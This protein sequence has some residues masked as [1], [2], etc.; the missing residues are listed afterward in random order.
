VYLKT[1][2]VTGSEGFLRCARHFFAGILTYF[3]EKWRGA[4]QKGP[5]SG[6]VGSFQIHPRQALV[7]QS[8]RTHILTLRALWYAPPVMVHRFFK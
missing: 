7:L 4:P 6:C 8:L 5:L 3:K 1:H 2:D